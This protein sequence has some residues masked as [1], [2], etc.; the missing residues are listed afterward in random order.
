MISGKFQDVGMLELINKIRKMRTGKLG[1]I[2][3]KYADP[4]DLNDY[5]SKV[6]ADQMGNLSLKLTRDLYQIQQNHAPITM[7]SLISSSIIFYPNEQISFKQIK[8]VCK[9]MYEYI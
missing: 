7:N 6:P 1:K 5:I 8:T 2:F 4:I 9:K 3:V